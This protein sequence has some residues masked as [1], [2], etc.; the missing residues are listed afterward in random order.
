MNKILFT[1]AFLMIEFL[2]CSPA[3]CQP[4]FNGKNIANTLNSSGYI[5]LSFMNKLNNNLKNLDTPMYFLARDKQKYYFGIQVKQMN[6]FPPV[7]T[8]ACMIAHFT[9]TDGEDVALKRKSGKSALYSKAD[10]SWGWELASRATPYFDCYIFVFYEI[11]DFNTFANTLYA[12]YSLL[13][14]MIQCNFSKSASSRFQK[15]LL[16][17]KK[18]IDKWYGNMSQANDNVPISLDLNHDY[19]HPPLNNEDE[20][21]LNELRF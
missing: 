20:R 9:T 21:I 13:D 11:D 12:S 7:D 5:Q 8:T 17:E 19:E 6:T 1:I 4:I 2:R 18:V 15:A 16:R 14:G 10:K 3:L